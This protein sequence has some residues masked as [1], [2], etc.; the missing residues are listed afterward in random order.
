MGEGRVRA[1]RSS[2]RRFG[3]ARSRRIPLAAPAHLG[4]HPTLS[5]KQE[6]AF[7]PF[8]LNPSPTSRDLLLPL[9]AEH[10]FDRAQHDLD[11]EP[12]RAVLDVIEVILDLRPRVPD[13]A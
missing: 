1:W 12:E 4:P 6:R 3:R 8:T 2:P 5:R 11:V 9:H 13:R 7:Q 10:D